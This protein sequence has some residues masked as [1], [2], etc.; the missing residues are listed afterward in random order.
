MEIASPRPPLCEL[1]V[2]LEPFRAGFAE[3]VRALEPLNE[4]AAEGPFL[5]SADVYYRADTDVALLAI[6]FDE[7]STTPQ[8]LRWLGS[9]ASRADLPVLDPGRLGVTDRRAFYDEYLPTYRIKVE[10]TTDGPREALEELARLLALP[11][12]PVS[13]P[14][15]PQRMPVGSATAREP[16]P[17]EP[18]APT[19]RAAEGSQPDG[20][21][22]SDARDRVEVAPAAARYAAAARAAAGKVRD[23]SKSRVT[24]PS[25]P[26]AMASPPPAG[27]FQPVRVRAP[28]DPALAAP[29]V[30]VRFLRGDSWVPAR[31]RS[32][33]LKGAKLAAAAPPRL[34]DRVQL[35][36][37]YDALGAVVGCDVVRVIDAGDAARSGE[38]IG[39]E[40]AFGQLGAET[41]AQVVLILRRAMEAGIS[42]KPPP[43]RA[44]VRFPVHW[45]TRVITSW[46]ELSAAA[47]DMSKSG[48]FLAPSAPIGSTELTFQMPL[49]HAAPPLS[50]RAAIAR[51]VSDEMASE[52]GLS[53]G[54]GVRILDF[55][56][57]DGPRYE[58]FLERVRHRTEKRLVVGA[59]GVR[60]QDLSRGLSAAGYTVRASG[61]MRALID[62]LE[63]EPHP[64]DA[65]LIHA[66]L[67]DKDPDAQA[68]RRALHARQVPCI[69]VGDES[70]Q[71]ARTVVD[72]LL[73]IS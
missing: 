41:R 40:V 28:S 67:F 35:V 30:N 72:H 18:P 42:I 1:F 68:L 34:G 58:S 7:R 16:K 25:S 54:Y 71:R 15:R 31:L 52:R 24:V 33:S 55:S 36:F 3:F 2:V 29:A 5:Q 53:R 20:R 63:S 48:L 66:P 37:G 57:N 45:P 26:R 4:A 61:D 9:V 27:E 62:R 43:T 32:L 60:A 12:A 73:R 69:T 13:R 50:G 64:P 44:A 47:L 56:N 17:A 14:S 6:R 8:K 10:G 38:P 19:S 65:A 23:S 22:R 70:A 46:G 21:Y 11:D 39:F 49:D 59:R 51:E